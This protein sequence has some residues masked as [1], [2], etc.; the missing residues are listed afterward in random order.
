M[1]VGV[2][3]SE[4]AR[5]AL[6]W[7]ARYARE[8]DVPLEVVVAWQFPTSFGYAVPLPSDWDPEED[9]RDLL[10][11]EVREALGPEPGIAV[12]TEVVEGRPGQVLLDA[13]KAASVVVVGNRGRGELSG[14]L[15]GSVSAYLVTHAH[16]PV[17]VV[18]DGDRP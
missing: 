6:K 17:V 3:G 5:A 18:R 1:V 13:S 14:A 15:L 9:A 12:E 7:A 8:S 10:D 4:R 16:C 11:R 2:D